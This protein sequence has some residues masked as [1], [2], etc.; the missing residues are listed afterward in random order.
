MTYFPKR[1]VI[2]PVDFSAES[3]AA[4]AVGRQLVDSPEHLHI[5]HVLIDVAPLEAGEVWGV[6]DQ[7][8]RLEQ[9]E[10]A[11]R[12]KFASPEYQGA[13]LAV[14]LGEPAHGIA[15]YAQDKKAELIV[16][17][18]HGRTGITRLLIGSVAERVVRLAHCPVLVLRK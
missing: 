7:Q 10:K 6:I 9:A 2:V 18:S 1:T 12:E 17:P 15:D 14:L 11:L 5:I 16:I 13:K 4:A 3:L 8:P